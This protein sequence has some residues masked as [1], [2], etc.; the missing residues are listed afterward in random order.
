MP[1]LWVVIPLLLVFA[2]PVP[3][4]ADGR[5]RGCGAISADKR[6]RIKKDFLLFF[7]K[8]VG[9]RVEGVAL[10]EIKEC[11]DRYYASVEGMTKAGASRLWFVEIF[12]GKGGRKVLH[13]PE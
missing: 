5:D 3:V 2:R 12:K 1:K 7:K 10:G 8:E 13:R 6:E 9:V 4:L 11:T